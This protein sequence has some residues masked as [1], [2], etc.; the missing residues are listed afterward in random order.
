MSALLEIRDLAVRFRQGAERVDAL[1]GVSF[2]VGRGERVAVVGESGSG[3]TL[4]SLAAMHL[5][6]DAAEI[7]GGTI[8]FDGEDI[9]A[10]PE[11]RMRAL[12][13]RRMAMVFQNAAHSLNPLLTVGQQIADIHRQ[14]HGGSR[15]AAWERAVA[16]LEA[17]GIPDAPNRARLYPHEYSGGMA[18]RAMIAMALTCRPDLL[19]ADEPTSG[20]DVTIQ[21]QVLDL[22]REVT[23]ETGA[24]LILITH[25]IAQI[26]GNCSRVVV[27][28]GGMVME[29]GEADLVLS[30]PA[31]P[32]TAALLACAAPVSGEFPHIPGRA[33]DPRHRPPGCPFAPRCAHVGERCR[34]E[35]PGLRPHER[36]LVACHFPVMS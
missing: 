31:N 5:L 4:S 25:D 8:A 28:Y 7:A 23:D 12:R 35:R 22:I 34:T 26:P 10:A 24:A 19:I 29:N 36:R 6:P 20:L 16:A 32:Y 27:M 15:A 11:R 33:P 14:H 1:I 21:R 18:Q 2:E 30:R 9:A 17:T 13:G 3:K